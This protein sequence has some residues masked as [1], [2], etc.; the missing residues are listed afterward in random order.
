[1][2]CAA[3]G[4]GSV[5]R[6]TQVP[7]WFTVQMVF[8]KSF[9]LLDQSMSHL[10]PSTHS[11]LSPGSYAYAHLNTYYLVANGD[12][13]RTTVIPMKDKVANYTW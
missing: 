4:Q 6:Q 13:L 1:M 11:I 3:T 5:V 12:G 9:Y 7:V 2:Y 10:D 8:L